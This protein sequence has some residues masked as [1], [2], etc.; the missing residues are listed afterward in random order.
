MVTSAASSIPGLDVAQLRQDQDSA[1]VA[2]EAKAFDDQANTAAVHSTPTILV[3]RTGSKP[4]LV[5]LSSP[6]DGE[7]V[8]KAIEAAQS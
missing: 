4:K 2:D 5:N 1:G 6:S 7:S 3:G 8:A